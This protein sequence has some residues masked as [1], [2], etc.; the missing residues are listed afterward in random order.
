MSYDRGDRSR[1]DRWVHV[2]LRW[3]M[4]VSMAVLLIGL[5]LFALD[6]G[7]HDEADMGFGDIAQGIAAGNPIAVI[8]LG[9]ILLIATP[10][11]RVLTTLAI[12]IADREPRF[13]LVSMLVLGIIALAILLG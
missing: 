12:F 2:V 11:T 4:T 7:G 9:I 5:L 3:G 8:D 10:L 1:T 6:P 13:I